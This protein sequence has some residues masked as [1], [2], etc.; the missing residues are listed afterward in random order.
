MASFLCRM[1]GAYI[2]GFMLIKLIK[3]L[4]ANAALGL[5][6]FTAGAQ[7]WAN[8]LVDFYPFN[9][10]SNDTVGSNNGTV[11]N[12]TLT[13][14]RFNSPNSAY[15]FNGNS[16]AVGL[17][18]LTLN[19]LTAGTIS[20]WIELNQN[21]Q[22]VIFAKQH[23]GAN[24][25][26]VFTVGFTAP[27]QLLGDVGRLYF[28]SQ[29][30][31]QVSSTTL[32][33]TGVWHHVAVA[34]S[35]TSCN[36]YIDGTPSGSAS[37]NFSIPDDTSTVASIGNWG[38]DVG[39]GMN[40]KIDDFRIFNRA[41]A[42]NEVAQLY[43]S[44]VGPPGPRTA[45][46]TAV[47]SFGFVV[48]V[49]IVDGGWG[50]TNTPAVHLI[51]GG[52]SGAGAVA[53]VSNGVVTGFTITSNGSGY[54][55]APQVVI[56]P[57]YIFNPVLAI[58][59][60]SFLTFSNLSVSG[61]YQLQRLAS[62]Y[63]TNQ[64]VSFTATNNV[65]TQMVAGVAGPGNYRLALSPVPAQA[66]ASPV[67]S[68][69]Y[70]VHATV[71][72]GGSGYVTSPPVSF[73]G[74]AGSNAAAISQ[75]SGGVV[76]NISITNPGSGYTN[77]PTIIIGQPPAAAVAP[78]VLPVMRVDAA[79]LAPYDNYQVQFAPN[80]NSTWGNWSGGLFTSTATTNSQYLFITNGL[81]YFRLQYVP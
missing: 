2:R 24:S 41:L 81:G 47:I 12:A 27:P 32:L 71:T 13:T 31:N 42:A 60:M 26:G 52:G 4:L 62:W 40:G 3:L 80:L 30:Y 33:S 77:T 39:I 37:G 17:S 28:Q 58:A 18:P 70:V 49:N 53:V 25:Y 57:P 48:N 22:E 51:G 74:G 11:I 36:L 46:G 56:D 38:G 45:N 1:D 69:G 16:A 15:A 78:T 34:F 35:S 73:S 6:T 43:A 29:N 79:S 54:T 5:V 19:N 55:N 76:T 65:Y 9:G 21:T 59:P 7:S 64:P 75:I 44:E 66:F 67:V 8:G 61:S 72:S 23:P 68:Y 20:T 63:W 10:N 14:D 50:Y